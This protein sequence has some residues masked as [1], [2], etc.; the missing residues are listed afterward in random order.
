MYK[1]SADVNDVEII[2]IKLT[3][4][5]QPNVEEILKKGKDSGAKL[6]FLCSPNNP[7][8]NLL[9][10]SLVKQILDSFDGMVIV[11][12][13]YIDFSSEPS[14]IAELPNYPNLV[15]LQTLSKA[16]GLANL[17]IGMLFASSELIKILNKIKLPYNISGIAQ[18]QALEAL[19]RHSD[20]DAM[21]AEILKQRRFLL[22][23]LPE[24]AC[25]THVYPS[26][27]NFILVKTT[28]P[29]AIYNY[30]VENKIVVRNRNNIL[31]CE[32]CLRIT[33]GTGDEN[34]TLL[35]SLK[36]IK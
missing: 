29:N 10:R 5:F 1:V 26:D 7:T 30:L 23:E 20:K 8:G 19:A 3:S 9:E 27:A 18:Q 33:V 15:V 25:V 4:K 2:D 34:H 36:K 12:E 31:L 16:W 35:D 28:N 14:W 21:V 11:D 24:V 32:G 6:L 13:A 22:Q 17:R